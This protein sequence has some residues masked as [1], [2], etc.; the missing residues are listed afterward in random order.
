MR[1]K[2]IQRRKQHSRARAE[3][4]VREAERDLAAQITAE[5]GRKASRQTELAVVQ[6]RAK[7]Y[8]A[9]ADATQARA[10][11]TQAR[12]DATQA[13]E[14]WERGE[15]RVDQVNVASMA[16]RRADRAEELAK[17]VEA[18]ADRANRAEELALEA[19]ADRA[20]RTEELAPGWDSATDGASGNTYYVNES[21]GETRWDPPL[22][23]EAIREV[24]AK[25]RAG[26]EAR[27]AARTEATRAVRAE[28]RADTAAA[29]ADTAAAR[30][31]ELQTEL[32]ATLR[33]AREQRVLE[34][35]WKEHA[36]AEHA[37]AD[38]AEKHLRIYAEKTLVQVEHQKK[39]MLAAEARTAELTEAVGKC[40]ICLEPVTVDTSFPCRGCGRR[41]HLGCLR[42]WLNHG[43]TYFTCPCSVR[44]SRIPNVLRVRSPVYL[45][46]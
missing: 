8:Q 36:K 9:R 17:A 2:R 34:K 5:A 41:Y 40:Q 23:A 30:A 44:T 28:A 16:A 22:T 20:D 38:T 27:R 1:Q 31:D 6:A 12:A 29:R 46:L 33:M 14:R 43:H 15:R 10:D 26:T 32:T 7:T 4:L 13:R 39:R 18:R 45:H 19:H 24:L 42:G 3:T 21:T 25:A 37:R 35:K 11:A